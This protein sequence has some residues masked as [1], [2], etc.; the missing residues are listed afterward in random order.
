MV[1]S[2]ALCLKSTS[3]HRLATFQVLKSH[4]WL[5]P[6]TLYSTALDKLASDFKVL[7]NATETVINGRFWFGGLDKCSEF[8]INFK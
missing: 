6:I 8:L 2:F 4:T 7:T 1:H 3:Q 5:V